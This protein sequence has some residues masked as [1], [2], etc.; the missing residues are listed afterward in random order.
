MY[1]LLQSPFVSVRVYVAGV[2]TAPWSCTSLF[3][4]CHNN[5]YF[6]QLLVQ[7]FRIGFDG[8]RQSPRQQRW[9][10]SRG[11]FPLWCETV[12]SKLPLL[13]RYALAYIA[14]AAFAPR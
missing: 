10:D 4:G 11:G 1:L 7:G 14:K 12:R 5:V 6:P 13:S 3:A 9:C 8:S 2:V